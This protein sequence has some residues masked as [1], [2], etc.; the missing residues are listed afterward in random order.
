MQSAIKEESQKQ[1]NE[2]EQMAGRINATA[3]DLLDMK[4]PIRAF[5][6][7]RKKSK[8]KKTVNRNKKMTC[9]I[10]SSEH[11]YHRK[12]CKICARIYQKLKA[13]ELNFSIPDG[14][15]MQ[16]FKQ[17]VIILSRA[18]R[19]KWDS[20]N[21]SIDNIPVNI[22]IASNFIPQFFNFKNR[23]EVKIFMDPTNWSWK[24]AVET[25]KLHEEFRSS[26]GMNVGQF[27]QFYK[28]TKKKVMA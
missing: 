15:V 10:C 9:R 16:V 21:G 25:K 4:L 6:H 22:Q 1:V 14:G 27:S 19:K 11:Y 3:S 24:T 7:R 12:E 26:P 18:M 23:N 13:L 5:T 20:E 8:K 17:E 28:K 2:L